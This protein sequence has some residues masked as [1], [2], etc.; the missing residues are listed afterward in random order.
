MRILNYSIEN[1][2]TSID[3][4]TDVAIYWEINV[5]CW[6]WE[7]VAW[8]KKSLCEIFDYFFWAGEQQLVSG[9][10]F[11]GKFPFLRES[12]F[13]GVRQTGAAIRTA[14]VSTSWGS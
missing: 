11:G 9:V 7:I 5:N 2:K 8:E 4:K 14:T 1:E 10:Y 13:A 12:L 6:E 3:K